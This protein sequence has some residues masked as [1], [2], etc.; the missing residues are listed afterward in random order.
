MTKHILTK[1]VPFSEVFGTV[2]RQMFFVCTWSFVFYNNYD[3][4][5][6][7]CA[8]RFFNLHFNILICDFVD[9]C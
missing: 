8:S 7:V 2:K 4:L 6:C 5:Q 1:H 3:T 9:S